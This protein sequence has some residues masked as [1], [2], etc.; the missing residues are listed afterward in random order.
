M[1][2]RTMIKAA[3]ATGAASLV[4]SGGAWAASSPLTTL[5]AHASTNPNTGTPLDY[6]INQG[7][8]QNASN[9][10]ANGNLKA[11]SAAA[12]ILGD[13]TCTASGITCTVLDGAGDGMIQVLVRNSNNGK[14]F[15]QL[16]VGE[17]NNGGAYDD[18]AFLNE[19]FVTYNGNG[20]FQ[21]NSV[22]NKSLIVNDLALADPTAE[23]GFT[24]QSEWLHGAF[25]TDSGAFTYAAGNSGIQP[26]NAAGT[27]IRLDAIT[28]QVI[29]GVQAFH[30][31]GLSEENGNPGANGN[32]NTIVAD[33]AIDQGTSAATQVGDAADAQ[34][35][36]VFAYRST[37]GFLS[38]GANYQPPATVVS[39]GTATLTVAPT[40]GVRAVYV[41]QQMFGFNGS[42]T[43]S[44][45]TDDRTLRDFGF[46]RYTTTNGAPSTG[47]G[48][49]ASVTG[50]DPNLSGINNPQIGTGNSLASIAITSQVGAVAQVTGTI[51][52]NVTV[53]ETDYLNTEFASNTQ[54]YTYGAGADNNGNFVNSAAL[55]AQWASLFSTVQTG[56]G[57]ISTAPANVDNGF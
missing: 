8:F 35:M 1:K 12:L 38:T 33:I 31:T 37:G 4:V 53:R 41:G 21:A 29:N 5:S 22:A 36:G 47:F 52:Q 18:G 51:A 9:F 11:S 42:Q 10:D 20:G 55:V 3:M 7:A 25:Q 28:D 30:Y 27:P 13:S 40:N 54:D 56:A 43:D 24:L 45:A 32:G 46:A 44:Y 49:W 34:A 19:T 48:Y 17:L 23:G 14:S 16:L 57:N 2:L 15:I 6:A 39:L 26:G 50:T